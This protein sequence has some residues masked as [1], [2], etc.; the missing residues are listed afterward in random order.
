MNPTYSYIGAMLLILGTACG[1]NEPQ[2]H[3]SYLEETPYALVYFSSITGPSLRFVTGDD[4]PS[5]Q[6]T[7]R[8]EIQRTVQISENDESRFSFTAPTE[9]TYWQK[10]V[11][12]GRFQPLSQIITQSK[13]GPY[14]QYSLTIS[15]PTSYGITL[16]GYRGCL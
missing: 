11:N 5:L 14:R 12:V 6:E 1:E 8:T 3:Q 2:A 9:G 15:S 16:V 7:F 13:C 4:S 10:G